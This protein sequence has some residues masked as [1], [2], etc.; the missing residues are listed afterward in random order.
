MVKKLTEA[1]KE[2]REIKK[3][4]TKIQKLVKIHPQS[5]VERACYKYK[6]AS[7]DKRNAEREMKELEKKLED[8]KRRLK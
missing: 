3:V 5:I 8:A 2:D 6:M 1:E 4:I 7:L